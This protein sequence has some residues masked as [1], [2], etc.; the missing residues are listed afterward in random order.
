MAAQN[1]KSAFSILINSP[2]LRRDSCSTFTDALRVLL[3]RGQGYEVTTSEFV[4]SSHTPKNMLIL[5]LRRGRYFESALHEYM[6]LRAALGAGICLED[7]LTDE[8]KDILASL[9]AGT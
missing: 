1:F 3:M 6:A 2:E 5:G 8:A 7:A 9:R 4:P